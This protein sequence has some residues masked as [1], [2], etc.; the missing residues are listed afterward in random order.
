[1]IAEVPVLPLSCLDDRAAGE[2]LGPEKPPLHQCPPQ[3]YLQFIPDGVVSITGA[4]QGAAR[5]VQALGAQPLLAAR[6]FVARL[7]LA[8]TG[9]G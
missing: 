3:P 5:A 8:G 7:T 9:G 4:G 2:G 6:A 1:M